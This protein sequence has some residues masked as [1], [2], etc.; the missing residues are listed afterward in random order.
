MEATERERQRIGIVGLGHVGLPTAATLAHLGHEVIGTDIDRDKVA[1]LGGGEMPFYEPE[2]EG[3]VHEGLDR[4]SLSFSTD[5]AAVM[6]GAGAVFLCVGTPPRAT[7]EANLL[8][9]EQSARVVAE[10]ATETLV[11]VEKSTVP[12]GTADRIAQTLARYN[13]ETR[14]LL[15]CNPEFLREGSAVEDSLRPPRLL[16]GSDSHEA[17]DVMRHVYRS[18]IDAGTPYIETDLRTAE[19]AKHACNAFLALKISFANSLARICELSAANVDEVTAIMGSD[20]RIGPSHLSAGLGYGGSCFPKDLV[21]FR[22][23]VSRLGYDFPLLDEVA[24]INEEAL[25]AAYAKV[26][27]VLWHLDDK[28]IALLGL[29]FKPDTDDVRFAPALALARKLVDSGAEVAGY[30][31]RAGRAAEDDLPALRV[32]ETAYDALHGAHCAVLCTE[33]PEFRDLDFVK[34]RESMA[35]PVIV[36]G[37]NFLDGRALSALDFDYLPTGKSQSRAERRS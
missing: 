37:R 29:A 3:L 22:R 31:P 26:E 1:R 17:L 24:R 5:P 15:V 20:P 25:D 27:E 30:D 8:A 13:P 9:L 4:G 21:A 28:R 7:G 23:L 33:W 36:D 6:Q 10:H 19:I 2:L 16:M 35:L 18:L 12:V 32:A 11:V 14:F 34:I